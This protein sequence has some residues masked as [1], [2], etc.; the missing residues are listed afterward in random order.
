MQLT[1]VAESDFA[2]AS[3]P[4]GKPQTS[5]SEGQLV[6]EDPPRGSKRKGESTRSFKAMKRR[7]LSSEE[8]RDLGL[9]GELLVFAREKQ[10]L[11]LRGR[12]DLANG[13]SHVS[14]V[15]GDGAGY[16]IA[17][18]F[19]DG[20]PK[21]IEVKTTSG[22]KSAEFFISPG[23]VA[24]S[25]ENMDQFELCRVFDFDARLNCARSYSIF[26]AIEDNFDLT[27]TQFRA[28]AK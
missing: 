2:D 8:S 22:P 25:A 16:D 18:F 21:F 10:R 20:R 28:R 4:I 9:K 19:D 27:E 11:A 13:V 3:S 17:S 1:I 23:E 15:A 12:A 14:V 26:G 5:E 24:F 6:E 7:Y